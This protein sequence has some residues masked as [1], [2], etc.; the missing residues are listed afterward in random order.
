VL[1]RG[2]RQRR[3]RHGGATTAPVALATVLTLWL[4]AP[5]AAQPHFVAIWGARGT[6]LGQF[7]AP[8]GV[9]VNAGDTLYVADA[10]LDRI[11]L[12]DGDGTALVAWNLRG[13]AP[14]QLRGPRGLAVD[15]GGDVYVA[16]SGNQRIQRF[17][18]D[19][20]FIEVFGDSGSAPGRFR[21]PYGL[22]LTR[23]RQLYVADQGNARVQHFDWSES[24]P[25]FVGVIGGETAFFVSPT[26][27]AV[28]SLGFLY[29]ADLDGREI[30]QFDPAGQE[31]R[32]FH[33]EGSFPELPTPLGVIVDGEV[34]QVTDVLNGI[35][36]AFDRSGT[37]LY[38]WPPEGLPGPGLMAIGPRRRLFV[39][40]GQDAVIYVYQLAVPVQSH[41][42]GAV[43]SLF[44]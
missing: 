32:R 11:T 27:V 41:S 25:R 4:V 10:F 15:A 18:R 19:G 6:G 26:S 28:D 2:R 37:R 22:T 30:V 13:S 35:V 38:G 44:R 9:A 42:F 39:S 31:V 20:T 14:G 17:R 24:P 23:D 12:F 36:E 21:G 29:V 8:T 34:L 5:L 16:D 43:K 1:A 3:L 7:V 40:S 33:G